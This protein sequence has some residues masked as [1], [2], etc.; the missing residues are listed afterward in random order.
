MPMPR[1]NS[2]CRDQN[3]LAHSFETSQAF[4]ADMLNSSK[5]GRCVRNCKSFDI[6]P[7]PVALEFNH[8][9]GIVSFFTISSVM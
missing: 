5:V 2:E 3:E 7:N 6:G 9:T 1:N 8:G 4:I